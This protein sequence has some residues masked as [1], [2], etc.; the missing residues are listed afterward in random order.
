MGVK[1][2]DYLKTAERWRRYGKDY[3][4]E[5]RTYYAESNKTTLT[6]GTFLLGFIG[7]LLQIG[8]LEAEPLYNKLFLSLGFTSLII[9]TVL[10]LFLFRKI[11]EFLNDAGDYYEKL[12]ENLHLWML[13]HKRESGVEYPKEIYQ[14]LKLK[15]ESDN[16]LWNA[17]LVF[18][19]TGFVSVALYFFLHLFC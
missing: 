8:N 16:R 19:G 18:L 5:S 4:D 12:S 17:Q 11:N 6:I 1:G 7:I 3:H 13:K 10:G 9:S 2:L 14:G 15:I